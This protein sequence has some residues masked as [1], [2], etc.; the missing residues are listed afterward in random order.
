[1]EVLFITHK[2]PPSI[3]GMEKQSYELINGFAKI[4]KVHTLVYDNE[5]SKVKFL[6]KAYVFD[7]LIV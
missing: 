5:S 6:L 4:H 7:E 1:M 2:Y 3:G